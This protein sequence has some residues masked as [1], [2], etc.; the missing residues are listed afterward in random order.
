MNSGIIAILLHQLPYQ[1]RGLGILSTIAFVLDFVLFIVFSLLFLARFASFGRQA[2]YQVTGDTAELALCACWPIAWLTLAAL[3]CLIVSVA[4]WGGHSFTIVGYVMWWVG[5][6]WTVAALLFVVLTTIRRQHAKNRKLPPAI[7]IPAV[8]VATVATTGGLIASYSYNMSDRMAVPVIIVSYMMVGI[9][10]LLAII[11]YTYLLHDLFTEGWPAP[12]QIATMWLFVGPM[13]QSAAALQ[14]LGSAAD[15]YGRFEGYAKGTFLTAEAAAALDVASILLALLFT[16]LG[17]I[18]A[19]MAFCAMA[20]KAWQG[21]LKWAPT[22]NCIIFPTGTL[23]TSFLLFSI[24]MDSSAFRVITTALIILLV[25]VFSL[26]LGFT[27][28]QVTQGKLLVVRETSLPTTLPG[29]ER[30]RQRP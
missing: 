2:Y 17:T 29:S 27:V 15:K 12:D 3:V 4:S 9:G 24:E 8:G 5:V 28:W 6:G 7:V 22:W 23:T 20:E 26:N 1:F 10:V 18:W 19:L 21:R 30:N 11:I 14:I 13:G 25:V 16:G